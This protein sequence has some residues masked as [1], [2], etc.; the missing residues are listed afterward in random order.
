MMETPT[1]GA[2]LTSPAPDLDLVAGGCGWKRSLDWGK[3]LADGGG[4]DVDNSVVL[5]SF[6]KATL[7]LYPLPLGPTYLG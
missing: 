6:L 5:F 7:R 1:C 2:R 4:H 3:P